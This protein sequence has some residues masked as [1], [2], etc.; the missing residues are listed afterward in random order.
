MQWAGSETGVSGRLAGD[1]LSGFAPV[2]LGGAGVEVGQHGPG[3]VVPHAEHRAG[4]GRQRVGGKVGG[5]QRGGQA[6]VL[7]AHLDGDR[8]AFGRLQF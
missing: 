8:P 1:C 3:N 5:G 4:D 2:G 6:G 7:H